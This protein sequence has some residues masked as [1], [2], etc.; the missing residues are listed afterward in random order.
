[1]KT[2]FADRLIMARKMAGKSLQELADSLGNVIT[3]KA[4]RKNEQGKM[5]PNSNLII[6]LS[7]ALN[8]TVDFFFSDPS[9][10]VNLTEVDFRKYISKLSVTEENAIKEKAKDLLERYLELES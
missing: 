6:K 4:L 2:S 1:M 10:K 7:E 3:K 9:V 8:V 5:K